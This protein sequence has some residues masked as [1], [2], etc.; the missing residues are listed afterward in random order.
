MET[1]KKKIAALA[2]VY[3]YLQAQGEM[4]HQEPYEANVPT[5][6]AMN[7]RQ[8]IMQMRGFVQRRVLRR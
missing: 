5:P 2:G 4:S 1:D 7:G 3:Y 6:W 8:S